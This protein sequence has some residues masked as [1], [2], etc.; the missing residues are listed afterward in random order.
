MKILCEKIVHTD[1]FAGRVDIITGVDD[2][3]T[4]IAY[5]DEW[6][7][8]TLNSV[9]LPSV[10]QILADDSY[11]FVSPDVLKKTGL[12]GQLVHKEVQDFLE[13]KKYGYTKEFDVFLQLFGENTHLF[14]Q[15]AIFDI[16]TT[17]ALNKKKTKKQCEM[18]AE[19]IKYITGITIEKLYAIWLPSEKKGKIIEL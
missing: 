9:I 4:Q 7:C 19:G 2:F 5:N 1:S 13:Q 8:Y 14:N 11:A 16:K 6:H 10:T 12:K 17:S 15:I 3:Q 18:Y